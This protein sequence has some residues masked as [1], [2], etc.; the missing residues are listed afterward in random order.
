M[1]AD[2]RFLLDANVFIAAYQQYYN[3]DICRGFWRALK[4]HHDRKRVFS[5]DRV[6]RELEGQDKLS[7]WVKDEAPKTFFKATAD[8][9]VLAAYKDIMKWANA[10]SQFI[11]SAKK[12]F[13][14][15]ADGWLVAFA[16]TNNLILVTHEAYRPNVRNRVLLPNVCVQFGVEYCN[17]FEMLRQLGVQFVLRKKRVSP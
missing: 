13:A 15:V 14:T 9:A 6:R 4:L 5:I 16:K 17:T 3:F 1:S 8:Q 2:S 12:E 10:E 7:A 11:D